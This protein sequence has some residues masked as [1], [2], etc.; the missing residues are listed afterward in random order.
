MI[1]C[2]LH[3]V[4]PAELLAVH[5]TNHSMDR[6]RQL[7]QIHAAGQAG[8]THRPEGRRARRSTHLRTSR[9][10]VGAV[11]DA[12]PCFLSLLD[13]EECT[14]RVGGEEW[15]VLALDGGKA[16]GVC[17]G[18]VGEEVVMELVGAFGETSYE[19]GG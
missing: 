19:D 7:Q 5:A 9:P 2:R 15:S 4:K 14:G 8:A 16:G 11:P 18:G 12:L 13:M 3:Q 1:C 17:T 10:L 6:L